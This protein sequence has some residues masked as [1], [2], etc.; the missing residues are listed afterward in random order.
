MTPLEFLASAVLAV[1]GG[2]SIGVL[3]WT[4]RHKLFP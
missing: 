1:L 4:V 2:G 3:V